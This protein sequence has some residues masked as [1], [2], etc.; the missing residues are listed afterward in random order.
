MIYVTD[1]EELKRKFKQAVKL[2]I[3]K[4]TLDVLAL[5]EGY[6]KQ[7]KIRKLDEQ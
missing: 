7:K 2:L 6:V 3:D 4:F 5:M 1:Q